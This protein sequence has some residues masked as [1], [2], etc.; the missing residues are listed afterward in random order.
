[1]ASFTDSISNF[2]PYI[3][4]LPVDAMLKVGMQK[5]AQYDQGVQ[6][7][8]SYV[9]NIAGMDVVKDSQKQYLQSKMNELGSKL[10]TVAA[11]DFSNQQLVSSVGGMATQLVKDP[12]VQSSVASAQRFRKEQAKAEQAK[13]EGKSS[14]ENEAYF[15]NQLNNW[16]GDGKLDSSFNGE[17][18]NYT[19]VG[20]KLRDIADKI[21][22]VDSSIDMPYQRDSS[23]NVITDKNGKPLVD[24]AMLRT[25]TK[26]KPAQKILDTFMDS[27]DEKDQKQLKITGWYHY[28][29]ANKDTFKSD[30]VSNFTTQKKML[31]DNVAT[32][33]VELQTN[34]KLTTAQKAAIQAKINSTNTAIKSGA[35]DKEMNSQ[36]AGIDHIQNIDDYK[37]KLYTQ[38]Y[39]TGLA[40]DMSYQ[41]TKEEILNNPYKQVELEVTKMN[42]QAA[43]DRLTHMDRMAAL[44]LQGEKF[45]WEKEQAL[46][47]AGGGGSRVTAA[48]IGTDVEKPSLMTLQKAVDS[49][50]VQLK[51][52]DAGAGETLYSKQGGTERKAS[53]DLLYSNYKIN[54][55]VISNPEQRDYVEARRMLEA[56][57]TLKNNLSQAIL[58]KSK[59]FD[60]KLDKAVSSDRGLTFSNGK[61]LY[62]ARDLFEI[63]SDIKSFYKTAGASVGGGMV[64]TTTP[65][66]S[67]DSKALLSK[68]KGTKM[69][70]AA[71]AYTKKYYGQPLTSTEQSIVNRGREIGNK[72]TSTQSQILKEK[73]EFQSEQVAKYMP[74]VQ[75]QRGT[76]NPGANKVDASS[77]DDI[78]TT[79][80]GQFKDKGGVDVKGGEFDPGVISEWRTGKGASDLKYTI[81]KNYDGSA[82][83]IIQKGTET[84]TVP[85]T[86][87]ELGVF[88]PTAAKKS[89]FA[90]IKFNVLSSTNHTTNGANIKDDSGSGAVSAYLSG[91]NV[92]GLA[93]T[94]YASRAR[95]DIEGSSNNN[96]EATDKYQLKMY[97]L[98]DNNIWKTVRLNQ[99]QWA[100]EAGVLSMMDQIGT[101]TFEDVLKQK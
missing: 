29:D 34:T 4:Q 43:N 2:N 15:N 26:G 79:K 48:G 57:T 28:K 80:Y 76:L 53:L 46:L 68:Y 40:K 38:K 63:D 61:Q 56:K 73:A 37:Y 81:E 74:E 17:Y 7:I 12:I 60:E 55:K 14:P 101:S 6:K 41:S 62:S 100:T 36:L 23:G 24:S 22:E 87:Q 30:I 50:A 19:D 97:V 92:P 72:Y 90:D 67:F 86:A 35:L 82:K 59:V 11:G 20:K 83:M 69:E 51:Q 10:K 99:S 64:G 5:Q 3:Q 16:L 65:V 49:D 77:I 42:L 84:Q 75:V 44:S 21:H 54:P 89:P 71:I 45:Q 32:L 47:A 98:D 85:M 88:F 39:L 78:L 13:K 91:Y 31:S 94:K 27:L 96:G 1:M 9:D 93:Q 18:T 33:A 95:F 52:L 70:P 8:Q 25:V 58:E 66:T